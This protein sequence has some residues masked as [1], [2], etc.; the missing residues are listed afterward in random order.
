MSF[1]RAHVQSEDFLWVHTS[2]LEAFKLYTR[3]IRWQD[4][5][6]HMAHR[7]ALLTPGIDN[8]WY[9]FGEVLVRND[10]GR[11]LPVGFRGRVWLLYTMRADHWRWHPNEPQIMR[12]ILR[13]R[14]CVEMP[15]PAFTNI[16][17]IP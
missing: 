6:A 17:V 10:F 1:L 16:G 4:A 8:P 11:A 5:P 7:V 15:T 9:T 3:M 13:E 14:G 2:S 12:T